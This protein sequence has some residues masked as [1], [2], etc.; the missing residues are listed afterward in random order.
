M[1]RRCAALALAGGLTLTLTACTTEP[2]GTPAAD[3]HPRPTAD[4][5]M[6]HVHGLGV[7]PADGMLYAASHF[8]LFRVPEDGDAERVADR[9]QDTMGFTVAG[10]NTFVGS[11]HPD[12]QESDLPTH[13][14]LIR[15]TDAG[16]TW[17]IVS[18]GGE[19][20]FH[21]LRVAHGRIYGWD[22][23]TGRLLVSADEGRTWETRSTLDLRDLAVHPEDPEVLLATT[24][25]GLL[26]SGDGG[27]TWTAV[28]TAPAVTVLAWPAT[29][30]LYGVTP[31]GV[32]H[33]SPDGGTTWTEQGSVQAEPEAL[34]VDH[35]DGVESI[36][37]AVSPATILVSTNGGASFTSRYAG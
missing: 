31:D 25:Q 20:D 4:V 32:V 5:G 30:S 2:S 37:V 9:Y 27:R 1:L 18:L 12:L 23:T 22:S 28:P 3:S 36:Y 8:G 6:E 33:E 14:G 15:S 17:D 19:V 21:A 34:L 13:L 11:G 7:D 26:R 16:E 24:E 10:P 35:R 29:S